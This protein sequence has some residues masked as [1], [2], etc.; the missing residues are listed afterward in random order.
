MQDLDL[1]IR[2]GEI[3]AIL[4]PNGVGKSLTLHTLAGLRRAD[5]GQVTLNDVLIG[6]LSRRQIA[7]RL[8]LLPQYSEDVFPASVIDTVLVG[9]HPHIARWKWETAHDRDLAHEALQQ[10]DL[11]CLQ[12]RYVATL[13][14]GERRRLAVAQVIAQAPEIYLLDEP[15]NHLDPQHQLDVLHL[16]AQRARD[17]AAVVASLHDIN[18]AARFA[19]RCLLLYGDGRWIVGATADVLSDDR[20]TELYATR[21]ESVAWREGK[22]FVALG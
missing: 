10:V 8:A 15:T 18:L 1:D 19:S 22:I 20:L 17:G 9:R 3:L 13:S 5:S 21:M 14:G 11:A 12:Q 7:L 16:F 6:E 2:P 4:G